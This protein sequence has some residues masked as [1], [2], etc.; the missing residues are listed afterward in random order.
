[1]YTLHTVTGIS[2]HRK[3]LAHRITIHLHGTPIG[4]INLRS[5]EPKTRLDSYQQNREGLARLI[6]ASGWTVDELITQFGILAQTYRRSK[7]AP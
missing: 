7:E 5:V 4:Q 3:P 6:E 2:Y 1:M